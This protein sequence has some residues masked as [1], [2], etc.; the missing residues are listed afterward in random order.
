MFAGGLRKQTMGGFQPAMACHKLESKLL[1]ALGLRLRHSRSNEKALEPGKRNTPCGGKAGVHGKGRWEFFPIS[2]GPKMA[3]IQARVERK[4]SVA[5]GGD[6]PPALWAR[7]QKQRSSGHQ[8]QPPAR[9]SS[10]ALQ[11]PRQRN[12]LVSKTASTP[13][14]KPSWRSKL[15]S[16][17][18]PLR[19]QL[20]Q[21]LPTIA[22]PISFLVL[23]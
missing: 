21:P 2:E 11:T 5:S 20:R 19:G 10:R 16:I 4:D 23:K 22:R 15:R 17:C 12:F 13:G 7:S 3:S 8:H 14:A 6:E 9:G 18:C 1:R